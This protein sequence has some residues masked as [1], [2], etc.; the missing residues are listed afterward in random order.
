MIESVGL[1]Q[2]SVC[3]PDHRTA[4]LYTGSHSRG[5]YYLSTWEDDEEVQV[6]CVNVMD[7]QRGT[8]RALT[9]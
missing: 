3:G 4:P 1:L 2:V 9:K 7:R 6:V 8:T 5:S